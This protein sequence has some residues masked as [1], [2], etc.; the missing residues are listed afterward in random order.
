MHESHA[1]GGMDQSMARKHYTQLG[2][3]LVLSLVIMYLAMFAMIDRWVDFFNNFN[4]LYMALLMWAPMAIVMLLTMRGMYPNKAL[5]LA[6]HAGFALV[7]ILSWFGIRDQAL[8]GDRQ[9]VR[10]MIPHHSG[11]VLMCTKAKVR[12][13]EIVDLCRGI[14]SSQT[15]EIAQMKAILARQSGN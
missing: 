13:P 11:A 12:D 5:N 2:A 3:N 6:L 4:M 8:V 9:F 7:F 14:V 15:S 10:S 1:Q